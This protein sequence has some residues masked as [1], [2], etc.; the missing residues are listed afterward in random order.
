M[1]A[2]VRALVPV[3]VILI[4][5]YGGLYLVQNFSGRRLSQTPDTGHTHVDAIQMKEGA[6]MPDVELIAFQ[7]EPVSG[8]GKPKAVSISSL[9]KKVLLIN[10]WA[11]W[12]PSCV[13]EMPSIMKLRDLYRDR[14]F[15]VVAI[16]VDENP[17]A[18]IPKI[19]K[20]IHVDIPVYL[21]TAQKLSDLFDVSAIPFTIIIDQ[22]RK[23][24]LTESGERDW[25]SQDVRNQ[26]ENWLKP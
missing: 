24:L 23:I 6:I 20:R 1:K 17:Q 16:N 12:C 4:L 7:P 19:L 14:G 10:F 13:T 21:D 11:S 3:F 9:N 18:V 8:G 2:I 5:V 26:M 15:D 22:H 25:Q